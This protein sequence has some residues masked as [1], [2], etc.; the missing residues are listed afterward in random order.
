MNKDWTEIEMIVEIKTIEENS[1]FNFAL[2]CEAKDIHL[3]NSVTVH[4]PFLV[5]IPGVNI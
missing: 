5:T 1:T 4:Y 2:E 3:G